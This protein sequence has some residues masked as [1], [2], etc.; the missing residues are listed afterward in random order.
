MCCVSIGLCHHA[1]PVLGV[2]YNPFLDELYSAYQG[3]GAW[4]NE[5]VPLPLQQAAR[6]LVTLQHALIGFDCLSLSSPLISNATWADLTAPLSLG[7][8]DR[9]PATMA[10]KLKT[11]DNLLGSGKGQSMAR[12]MRCTGSAALVRTLS[13]SVLILKSSCLIDCGVNRTSA[14]SPVGN[15]TC[16]GRLGAGNGCVASLHS[17]P[18]RHCLLSVF[19]HLANRMSAQ[20]LPSL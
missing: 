4:L 13:S 9:S 1:F 7:G 6:P 8:T 19:G 18:R 16:S 12:G 15:S 14:V 10:C 5:I 20:E 3:G 11:F 2:V 17:S